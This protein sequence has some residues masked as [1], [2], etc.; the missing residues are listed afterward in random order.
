[1][2]N[3]PPAPS[4]A[5]V[6][7]VPSPSVKVSPNNRTVWL[8]PGPPAESMRKMR[9]WPPPLNVTFV[10]PPPEPVSPSISRSSVIRIS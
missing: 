6:F 4:D 5:E 7:P 1:M 9:L 3:A 10:A 2:S 8:V